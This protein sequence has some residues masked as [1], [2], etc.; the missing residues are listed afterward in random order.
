LLRTY[1]VSASLNIE[2]PAAARRLLDGYP[3]LKTTTRSLPVV[4]SV[5]W[6][7]QD[8][9]AAIETLAAF[10][11]AEPDNFTGYAALAD[12]QQ[13]A[14][15]VSE[16][17]QTADLACARFPTEFAPRLVRIA[18]MAPAKPA[19]FPAWEREIN[20]YVQD[21]GAKPEAVLMLA[22]IS[23][24]KGWVDVARLL[25]EAG[26]GRQQDFRILAM[27]YSDALMD[28]GRFPEAQRVLAEIDRQT[29]DTASFSV[30]LWQREIVAAAACG[31]HDSARDSARRVASALR[32]NP[33]GLESIRQRFIKLKI[34]EAVAVLTLT[35]PEPK[36]AAPDKS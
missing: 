11:K 6:A 12:Y 21:F 8:Q 16:A 1:E 13:R 19:D 5:L 35:A 34:P 29:P 14:G 30:L 33:E 3:D 20:S 31:D 23:G 25:Y 28:Q 7:T 9:P 26:A 2:G 32:L 27:Y 36:A 4:A 18:I 22:E 17:R 24:Q 15:L 10:V